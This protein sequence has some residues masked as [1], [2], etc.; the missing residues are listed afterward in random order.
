MKYEVSCDPLSS[1]ISTCGGRKA[2]I[3]KKK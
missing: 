2:G 3:N 1:S